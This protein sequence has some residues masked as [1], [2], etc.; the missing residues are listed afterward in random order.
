MKKIKNYLEFM[1]ETVSITRKEQTLVLALAMLAGCVLGML[2]SPRKSIYNANGNGTQ[3]YYGP[4]G[5]EEPE[6]E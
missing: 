6:G 2:I 3:Y 5:E 1:S 4:S